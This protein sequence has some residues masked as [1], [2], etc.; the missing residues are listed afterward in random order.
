MVF[1]FWNCG[2]ASIV[3]DFLDEGRRI[4][5]REQPAALQIV[6][7]DLGDADAD[8]AVRGRARDEIGIRDRQRRES[9]FRDHQFR[10]RAGERGQKQAS[11]RAADQDATRE[12]GNGGSENVVT[13]IAG[14][15]PKIKSS[16]CG[17]SAWD[18]NRCP[19]NFH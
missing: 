16:N 3:D 14:S 1:Q 12:S 18:Q 17:Q 10:L 7:D 9:T 2:A 4:D 19:C 11:S 8:L 15:F 5:R 6:G 13:D